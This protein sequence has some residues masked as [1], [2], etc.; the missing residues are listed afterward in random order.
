VSFDLDASTHR[1]LTKAARQAQVSMSML[2]RATVAV[3]LS[4]LGGWRPPGSS[5]GTWRRADDATVPS[6]SAAS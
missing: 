3:L 6:S 2:L 4:R 5:S 1:A